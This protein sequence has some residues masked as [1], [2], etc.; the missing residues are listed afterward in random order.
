MSDA[1][2]EDVIKEILATSFQGKQDGAYA[3]LQDQMM[4]CAVGSE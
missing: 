3:A 1:V 2:T 4:D